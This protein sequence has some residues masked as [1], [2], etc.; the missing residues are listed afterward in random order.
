MCVVGIIN[1]D[2][3]RIK[4]ERIIMILILGVSVSLVLLGLFEV[5]SEIANLFPERKN[6]RGYIIWRN[7]I[8]GTSIALFGIA[9][10]ITLLLH[11]T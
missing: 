3:N 11:Q 1:T 9:W 8:I 10:L 4:A 6:A 5:A 2:I 7:V